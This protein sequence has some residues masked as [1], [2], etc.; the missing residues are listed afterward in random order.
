MSGVSATVSA[1]TPVAAAIAPSNVAEQAPETAGPPG[2]AGSFTEV[3]SAQRAESHH[4]QGERHDADGKRAPSHGAKE[5]QA[6]PGSPPSPDLPVSGLTGS[7]SAAAAGARG[8]SDPAPDGGT[9]VP[10]AAGHAEPGHPTPLSA[11]AASTASSEATSSHATGNT[12][13]GGAPTDAGVS[14]AEAKAVSAT[15]SG[16]HADEP[17]EGS[18]ASSSAG[19]ASTG[20]ATT[21]SAAPKSGSPAAMAVVT[22]HGGAS[23]H[24]AASRGAP[25]PV[26]VAS[27]PGTTLTT[28]PVPHHLNESPLTPSDGT[29]AVTSVSHAG[30]SVAPSTQS[31]AAPGASSL[32]VEGLSGSISRPLSDGNGTYTVTVVLHPQELGHVQAVMSLHGSDLPVSL[33][34]QSQAGHEALAN[35][36]DALK[37]QLARGGVNVNVTL[38]DPG[39]QAGGDHRYRPATSSGAGSLVTESTAIETPLPSG[40]ASG[41]I[42]LVL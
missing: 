7:V 38:R 15:G 11:L 9:P 40:V 23:T 21:A 31:A 41:Q 18:A 34:A 30:E 24:T 8:H 17:D 5:G 10:D 39:S 29:R 25:A 36:T 32:D 6:T 35:A 33:T 20:S 26:E 12:A 4:E 16:A 3:L 14:A 37:D 42:H 1:A 27:V 2:P 13:T 28:T 19:G 22:S